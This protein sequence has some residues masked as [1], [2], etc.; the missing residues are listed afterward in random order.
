LAS[1]WSKHQLNTARTAKSNTSHTIYFSTPCVVSVKESLFTL[2]VFPNGRILCFVCEVLI[3]FCINK[4]VYIY[5]FQSW[6][7]NRTHYHVCT[8]RYFFFILAVHLMRWRNLDVE[9]TCDKELSNVGL[10]GNTNINWLRIYKIH[11]TQ[12]MT[13]QFDLVNNPVNILEASISSRS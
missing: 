11:I 6:N 2:L 4:C 9:A 12:S 7:F 1:K 13:V 5:K 3:E 8:N 10:H